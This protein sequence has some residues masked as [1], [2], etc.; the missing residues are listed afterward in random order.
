[1]KLILKLSLYE[2]LWFILFTAVG[3]A[4][5]FIW[6][7]TII[8]F[9]AF[10]SGIICVLLAAKG[11]KWNYV[12]GVVNCLT[13][14]WVCYQ[15]GLFGEV[16]LNTMFYLPV[17]FVGFYLWG[18]K[19]KADGIVEMK[20]LSALR[21]GIVAAISAIAVYGYGLFLASLEGQVDPFVD[22]FTNVLTVA[23]ALLMLMRYREY[24]LMYILV[25]I[26]SVLL[27]VL[28][29]ADD[30]PNSVTMI[31]MWSAY[32]VNSVYGAF[33]WFKATK[34]AGVEVAEET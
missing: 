16:M 2:K 33:V 12:I 19:T 27:W 9:V 17:Q 22:S 13:Y 29:L 24:W 32:L 30:D 28:R 31:A 6:G 4:L 3:V 7:D 25:N 1:M 10:I 18:K 15:V 11:S 26:F 5:S 20:K 23:A 34:K 8:G 21:I 14:A